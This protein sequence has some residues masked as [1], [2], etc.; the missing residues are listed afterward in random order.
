MSSIRSLLTL[1]V[2]LGFLGALFLLAGL[3]AVLSRDPAPCPALVLA[4]VASLLTWVA[5]KVPDGRGEGPGNT[6]VTSRSRS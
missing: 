6:M 3:P 2:A 5:D 4:I 1:L